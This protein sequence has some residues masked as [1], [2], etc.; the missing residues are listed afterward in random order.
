MSPPGYVVE[1]FDE[2]PNLLR[3]LARWDDRWADSPNDWIYRGQADA[4]WDL[5]PSAF[6]SHARFR[7][8]LRTAEFRP[9]ALHRE[10]ILEEGHLIQRFLLAIDRQG[11]AL[12][13]EASF[14][15][16]DFGALLKDITA[17]RKNPDWPPPDI[18][19]LFA[20]A[21]HYGIP[22]RLLDWSERPLVAAYFAAIAGAQRSHAKLPSSGHIAVW[23]LSYARASM[24]AMFD[25]REKR[26]P[27]LRIVRPPRASN[28]NLR[29]QEGVFTVLVHKN[30]GWNDEAFFPPLNR[31]LEQRLEEHA[32]RSGDMRSPILYK[33]VLPISQSGRLLRLLADDWISATHLYPGLSGVVQGL[34]EHAFWDNV[35]EEPSLGSSAPAEPS[36]GDGQS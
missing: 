22:T 5:L 1:H 21:Q 13:T 31:L 30:R 2:A 32:E 24:A 29:A 25:I 18:A 6:R 12:P 23:A 16:R 7:Y 35:D 11:L 28:P 20:L 14:R 15:W 8:G 27:E 4:D 34:R 19:P 9:R 33:L 26:Q 3:A 17:A 10:Q 36:S